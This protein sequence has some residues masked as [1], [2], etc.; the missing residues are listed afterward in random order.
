MM[1]SSEYAVANVER[2]NSCADHAIIAVDETYWKF[3]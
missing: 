3:T 1:D 2:E